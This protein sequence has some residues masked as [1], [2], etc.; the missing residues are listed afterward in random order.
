MSDFLLSYKNFISFKD[1]KNLQIIYENEMQGGG[2][3]EGF[4]EWLKSFFYKTQYKEVEEYNLEKK[5]TFN[6]L[7]FNKLQ[8]NCN[9]SV[10][11]IGA[12]FFYYNKVPAKKDFFNFLNNSDVEKMM[13]KAS[14]NGTWIELTDDLRKK[15]ELEILDYTLAGFVVKSVFDID[16]EFGRDFLKALVKIS[17]KDKH[18]D[19]T[20]SWKLSPDALR[21]LNIDENIAKEEYGHLKDI[22]V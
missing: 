1:I 2:S 7:G 13:K 15:L 5:F 14:T 11:N 6:K 8:N 17:S 12:N 10:A 21:Q 9:Q 19:N 20:F 18:V 4:W 16:K 22:L 3:F